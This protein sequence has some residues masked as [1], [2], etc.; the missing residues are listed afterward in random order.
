MNRF[1]PFIFSLLI[2]AGGRLNAQANTDKSLLWRISGKQMDKPSYLFGTIH[3]ICK[4]DYVWTNKM[5]ESFDKSD[6]LCLEMD[7][8]NPSVL[9]QIAEG[10]IDSTGKKL[11]DYFT[12]AQYRKLQAYMMDSLSIDLSVFQQ[13]KPVVL[14]SVFTGKA[15]DCDSPV[16]YEENLAT[17]AKNEHKIIA[18]LEDPREQIAVLETIPT[19][20]VIKDILKSISG[21]QQDNDNSAYNKLLAAYKKQ[22]LPALYEM[23]QNSKDLQDDMGAFLDERNKKWID[24][25][26]DKMEQKSVF[27][28]VGAGHLWGPNGVISLLRK[29][30]YTVVPIK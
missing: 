29:A 7:I 14:E 21:G 11:S 2:L 16:S 30:G 22:D 3:L 19:D 13:M 18:G 4:N 12:P 28:A 23:I 26:V 6:E 5:K 25:M 10:F 15:A 8:T 1:F 9:M 27:F 24:R 20:S 17:A